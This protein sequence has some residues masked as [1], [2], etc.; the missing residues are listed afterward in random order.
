MYGC[1]Q[2]QGYNV[3]SYHTGCFLPDESGEGCDYNAVQHGYVGEVPITLT[4]GYYIAIHSL[5]LLKRIFAHF[6]YELQDNF[7]THT[8]P[9]SKMVVVNNV[10]DALVNGRIRL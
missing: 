10:M 3:P 4:P 6:G 1:G 5:L 7:F 9:F 2:K 8:E